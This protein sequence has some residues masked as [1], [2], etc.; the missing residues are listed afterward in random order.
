MLSMAIDAPLKILIW[1]VEE[2][3]F[4]LLN[5]LRSFRDSNILE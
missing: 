2:R 3:R 1:E 4:S 5:E